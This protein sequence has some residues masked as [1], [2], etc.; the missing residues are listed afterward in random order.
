MHLPEHTAG[1][2][3][4]TGSQPPL[5]A[6]PKPARL[7]L[8]LYLLLAVPVAAAAVKSWA[9]SLPQELQ[10]DTS[11]YDKSRLFYLT[12]PR[13]FSG[14]QEQVDDFL[15]RR[16]FSFGSEKVNLPLLPGLS[17]PSV[18][19]SGRA[20][21]TLPIGST[22][23]PE[24]GRVIEKFVSS[25]LQENPVNASA[26]GWHQAI[27]AADWAVITRLLIQDVR[28]DTA[29][30][31]C[32]A[33]CMLRQLTL[34]VEAGKMA[35]RRREELQAE[36]SLDERQRSLVGAWQ[37][38]IAHAVTAPPVPELPEDEWPST[39]AFRV[40]LQST[41][42]A[43]AAEVAAAVEVAALRAPQA[44]LVEAPPGA[45]KTH[46][47]A[48]IAIERSQAG[49]VIEFYG[50]QH[51]L[52]RELSDRIA[53]TPDSP[54]IGHHV[55]RDHVHPDG[56]RACRRWPVIRAVVPRL[57]AH[58]IQQ[59]FCMS[60]GKHASECPHLHRCRY[61]A[62]ADRINAARIRLFSHAA[63]LAPFTAGEAE[64]DTTTPGQQSYRRRV[65]IIDETPKVLEARTKLTL[66]DIASAPPFLQW[67]HMEGKAGSIDLGEFYSAFGGYPVLPRMV[68]DAIEQIA[69]KIKVSPGLSDAEIHAALRRGVQSGSDGMPGKASA[70]RVRLWQATRLLLRLIMTYPQGGR[71]SSIWTDA[72]KCLRIAMAMNLMDIPRLKPGP[73]APTILMLDATPDRALLAASGLQ[74]V[75]RT[76]SVDEGLFLVQVVNA[77]WRV[78]KI[79]PGKAARFAAE[80]GRRESWA[81]GRLLRLLWLRWAIQTCLRADE[82]LLT[83]MPMSARADAGLLAA[84]DTLH[85]GALRGIDAF[86]TWAAVLLLGGPLPPLWAMT[87]AARTRYPGSPVDGARHCSS[88]GTIVDANDQSYRL[89]ATGSNVPA[90]DA[91]MQAHLRDELRQAAYRLRPENRPYKPV[92]FLVNDTPLR[93]R[94]DLVID[95]ADLVPDTRECRA[96]ALI[97]LMAAPVAPLSA[98]VF[99]QQMRAGGMGHLIGDYSQHEIAKQM[100]AFDVASVN[101][102]LARIARLLPP[103]ARREKMPV[104]EIARHAVEGS[105]GRVGREMPVLRLKDPTQ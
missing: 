70:T 73:V 44:T 17:L 48:Q 28:V 76:I 74:V 67:L 77:D 7:R 98:R 92:A 29:T 59:A 94:V 75:S 82:K 65:V 30:I 37:R 34:A 86:G 6:S 88:A 104:V 9:M 101:D 69:P 35:G 41:R 85:Y 38:L 46:A 56:I 16:F 79:S 23:S 54:P 31:D 87:E 33:N 102:R 80:D 13:I 4:I 5:F 96:M 57:G 66:R 12:P 90:V 1:V 53:N 78:T 27:L 8:R 93:E 83:V 42:L 18:F 51:R 43:L 52:L 72:A 103:D 47:C 24:L 20:N 40:S 39:E 91:S 71:V 63:L 25:S 100:R 50:P 84:T 81:G 19:R 62:N 22:V 105:R 2:L 99:L 14:N 49:D 45:G 10:S 97:T 26:G 21:E 95:Y 36:L 55:G 32:A 60:S 3:Q 89:P 15:P 61:M 11:A 58:K 64:F 68:D